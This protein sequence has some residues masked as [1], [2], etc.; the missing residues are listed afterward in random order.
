MKCIYR[1]FVGILVVVM[2]TMIGTILATAQCDPLQYPPKCEDC[3]D[4][5]TV[6]IPLCHAG[7]NYTMDVVLCTQYAPL[8]NPI[9]NPCTP[10]CE[11]ALDAVTWVKSF[12]VSQSLKDLGETAVLSAIVVGTDLCCNNFL[13]VTL[14]V[15][16]AGTSCKLSTVA[17]CHQLA[18]PRCMNKN[19]VTGCYESCT[20]CTNFCMIERRYCKP[21][22]ETCCKEFKIT[23]PY[24]NET[25][26]QECNKR[27]DCEAVYFQASNSNCCTAP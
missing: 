10:G 7:V 13:G 2:A 16:D 26:C 6:T 1:S 4:W 11:R 19:Y 8:P 25:E 14:P 23:C 12:C 5:Q 9:D 15:C 21:T 3:I 18:M 24:A 22:P 17:F 27:W 20:Q